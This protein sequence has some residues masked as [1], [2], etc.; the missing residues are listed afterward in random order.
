[1]PGADSCV[2]EAPGG[3][4]TL[5][6]WLCSHAVCLLQVDTMHFSC[7]MRC[8]GQQGLCHAT[9]FCCLCAAASVWGEATF[10]PQEQ[11]RFAVEGSDVLRS[12]AQPG[13]Q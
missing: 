13:S 2:H 3:V 1:M 5:V 12:V 4:L 8:K 10:H 11:L 7:L 6:W 9:R